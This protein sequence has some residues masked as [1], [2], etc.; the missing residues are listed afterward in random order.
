METASEVGLILDFL[1]GQNTDVII[2]SAT[3]KE[4]QVSF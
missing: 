2:P 1:T 4:G 3:L